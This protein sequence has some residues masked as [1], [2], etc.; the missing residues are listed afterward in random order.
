MDLSLSEFKQFSPLF[1]DDILE[2]IRVE[3][4]V[5]ARNSYGGTSST[6]VRREITIAGTILAKQQTILD[7]YTKS[8]I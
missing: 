2:A 8:T 6:G 3:T 4:C 5:D 7:M 1:E